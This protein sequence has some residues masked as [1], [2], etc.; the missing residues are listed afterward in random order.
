MASFTCLPSWRCFSRSFSR[1]PAWS[2]SCLARAPLTSRRSPLTS[3]FPG[4]AS[5]A[6]CNT[7]LAPTKSSSVATKIRARPIRADTELGSSA[8][9]L[10][11]RSDACFS[12]SSATFSCAELTL[13]ESIT[14]PARRISTFAIPILNA[15]RLLKTWLLSSALKASSP[16][17]SSLHRSPRL[18]RRS[19]AASFRALKNCS[20]VKRSE[21]SSDKPPHPSAPGPSGA[22]LTRRTSTA[23]VMWLKGTPRL[24]AP[25]ICWTAELHPFKWSC[26]IFGARLSRISARPPWRRWRTTSSTGPYNSDSPTTMETGAA[27]SSSTGLRLLSL[28]D[29]VCREDASTLPSKSVTFQWI[30]QLQKSSANLP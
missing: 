29:T 5:W 4:S 28:M 16:A 8:R 15:R 12:S 7:S 10:S 19:A 20:A 30:W 6:C 24:P 18:Y 25:M 26:T 23:T 9:T 22:G 27:S 17:I 1:S 14:G 11:M 13:P 21:T 2:L 3:S